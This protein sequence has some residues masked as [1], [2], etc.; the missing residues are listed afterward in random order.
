MPTTRRKLFKEPSSG[1]VPV[2][3]QE[4]PHRLRIIAELQSLD[5]ILLQQAQA[6]LTCQ[7]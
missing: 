3:Q 6:C 7:Q 5:I 2:E 4:L 1:V